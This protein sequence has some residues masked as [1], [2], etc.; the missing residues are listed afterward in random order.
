[1]YILNK[2]YDLFRLMLEKKAELYNHLSDE[3]GNSQVADN[4]LV[5]FKG[6]KQESMSKPLPE[7]EDVE[8]IAPFV[9]DD[10]EW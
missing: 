6:K 5:D 4:F 10:N 3:A 2:Y 8:E 7:P 9:D 1:M